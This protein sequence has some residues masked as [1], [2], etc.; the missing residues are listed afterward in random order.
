MHR[1]L[2]LLEPRLSYS[3]QLI[4]YLY[5]EASFS[6]AEIDALDSHFNDM[7]AAD[8]LSNSNTKDLNGLCP[9]R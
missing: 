5:R 3:H 9:N 2:E 6:P 8:M 4:Q 1:L 7:L